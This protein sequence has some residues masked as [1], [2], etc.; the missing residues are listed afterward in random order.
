MTETVAGK[1]EDFEFAALRQATNYR[2]A[3]MNEFA[4]A[5][6]GNV[7]ETGAGIGQMTKVLRHHPL[8]SRLLCVEPNR[9]FCAEHRKNFAEVEL[10][11]GTVDDLPIDSVWDSIVS[12]NVL[13]HIREDERELHRYFQLLKE[14]QGSLCLIVPACPEIYAPIDRRFGHFRR[15]TK[16]ELV[17]KLTVAGFEI[18]KLVY[19]NLLGYFAWWVSF[20]LLKR[21]RFSPTQ[22]RIFDGSVFPIMNWFET[23][24]LRPPFGQSLV[25]VAVAR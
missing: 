7:L 14:R 24:L 21:D 17:E 12:V 5:V 19:F 2:Q 8:I 6:R 10:L 20:C 11:P 15:Y 9:E 13:E 4:S 22:V 16:R 25:V 3:L 23:K 18:E 1:A